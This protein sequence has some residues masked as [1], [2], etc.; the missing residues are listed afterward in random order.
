[1]T[2]VPKYQTRFIETQRKG[3]KAIVERDWASVV[4]YYNAQPDATPETQ[5][6]PFARIANTRFYEL[7]FYTRF[8]D[9]P[10]L[11][12]SAS[13]TDAPE[14]NN[15]IQGNYTLTAE[16]WGV[17]AN[18][19]NLRSWLERSA[20]AAA[21]MFIKAGF[22]VGRHEYRV[23]KAKGPNDYQDMVTFTLSN[24]LSVER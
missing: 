15:Y 17:G 11:I 9:F 18:P 24:T 3:A 2:F 14:M 4:A 13:T 12:L 23:M 7:F 8:E 20:T 6:L 19:E 5:L 16:I 21:Q 1:M 10:V 22:N